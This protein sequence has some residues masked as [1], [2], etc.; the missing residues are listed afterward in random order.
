MSEKYIEWAQAN[1]LA[2]SQIAFFL[3]L[4]VLPLV[5]LEGHRRGKKVG[6]AEAFRVCEECGG[7][8]TTGHYKQHLIISGNHRHGQ[9]LHEAIEA[10][11]Q[12]RGVRNN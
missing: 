3:S 5:F 11:P 8:Y 1:Q 12:D 4:L 10:H 9:A 7:R 6:R 2:M